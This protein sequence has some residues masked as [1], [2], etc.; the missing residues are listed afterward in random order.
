[1]IEKAAFTYENNPTVKW[2]AKNQILATSAILYISLHMNKKMVAE[3]QKLRLCLLSDSSKA[4]RL[5]EKD[6]E[7][8]HLND[9]INKLTNRCEAFKS[10]AIQLA[11]ELEKCSVLNTTMKEKVEATKLELEKERIFKTKLSKQCQR[12]DHLVVDLTRKLKEKETKFIP[13]Y[14]G[15][16]EVPTAN[17]ISSTGDLRDSQF[18]ETATSN[19]HW[20]TKFEIEIE[21]LKR[22]KM[23]ADAKLLV[24]EEKL[25]QFQ[26]DFFLHTM[27]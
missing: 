24:A 12:L 27:H 19:E 11:A 4:K 9:K 7:I 16:E 25:L 17:V 10:S 14:F 20:K 26:N 8:K 15:I 5:A 3:N 1:M 18:R 22:Q 6:L 13:E 23:Q 2:I 21:S